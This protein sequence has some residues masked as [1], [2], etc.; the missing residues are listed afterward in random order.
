MNQA[1]N[2][3]ARARVEGQLH[4][5][6]LATATPRHRIDQEHAASL[7]ARL[8]PGNEKLRNLLPILYRQTGI[9]QR[10]TVLLEADCA[11]SDIPQSFFSRV[12]TSDDHGP[13]TAQRM[14]QYEVHAVELAQEACRGA[15]LDAQVSNK[16]VT[17]L[18]TVSCSGFSAPGVDLQLIERLGLAPEVSRTHLGFMGCHGA[19]NGL[20]VANAYLAVDPNA[21]VLL[22]AVEL[23]SLHHQYTW[24][25]DQLI[26]NALFSDGAGA[27]VCTADADNPNNIRLLA[28]GSTIIPGTAAAM[29]WYIRD[30]G[31][32]MTLAQEVPAIIEQQLSPW[33]ND[34]LRRQGQSLETIGAW[35]IHPGGPRILKACATGLGLEDVILAP[36]NR[37]LAEHGNMSSPTILFILDALQ[38]EYAPLPWVALAF[39]PGLTIEAALFEAGR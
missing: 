37:V 17:H 32:E 36:S 29:G 21:V 14:R 16:Q 27:V 20:R 10:G 9:Q 33:L 19:L 3:I 31:F 35:A 11:E 4:L 8:Y 1:G 13:T 15:L 30:H 24:R 6:G 2:G 28:S 23:C 7:A 5:T 26:A 38:R 34:W 12:L 22:C 39:G 18:V 25:R